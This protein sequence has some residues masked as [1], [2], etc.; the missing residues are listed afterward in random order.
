MHILEELG[1]DVT[2]S[3]LQMLEL[4]LQIGNFI[5]PRVDQK[6]A[7]LDRFTLLL[8][9]LIAILILF[10]M[11]DGLKFTLTTRFILV[12]NRYALVLLL[13]ALVAARSHSTLADLF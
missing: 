4:E 8:D 3:A 5:F 10:F 11:L 7:W 12:N 1:V 2:M 9:D 6:W 13:W